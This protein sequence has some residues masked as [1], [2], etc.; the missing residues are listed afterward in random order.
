VG[1]KAC[2]LGSAEFRADLHAWDQIVAAFL[3][4]V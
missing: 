2:G 1:R 4:P 3:A